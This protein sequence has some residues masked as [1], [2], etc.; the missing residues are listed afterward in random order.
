MK[1]CVYEELPTEI[2]NKLTYANVF[3]QKCYV[4]FVRGDKEEVYYLFD[5]ERIM[6]VRYRKKY[7]FRFAM[8]LSEP[9]LYVEKEHNELKDFLN[10]A[11]DTLCSKCHIQWCVSNTSALFYDT[12]DRN[13]KRIPFGS[14]V[15][16][17]DQDDETIWSKVHSKHRNV[18]RKAEKEGVVIK[19]GGAELLDDYA[20]LEA[21]TNIR[22]GRTARGKAYYNKQVTFL[23]E[24]LKVYIAYNNGIPQ[25]GGIFFLNPMC[26]Y[27][28]FGATAIHSITGAANLLLWTA[29]K[30]A[31]EMK[32]KSFSF[33]G[34]RI[35]EDL[36]SKY[37]GIQRFKERFGGELKKGYLFRCE[38]KHYM[39]SLFCKAMQF[40][41]HQK[42]PY[43]TPIDDEL[44]KWVDIQ[45]KGKW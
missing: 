32:V 23:K 28:M 45:E 35:N 9:L 30:D 27:Y 40:R 25:A 7:I 6:P 14:H 2:K 37:H 20:C 29:I 33:V 10:S 44:H 21:E 17:L 4:D 42:A 18:I 3:F 5:N 39:Y 24:N 43:S 1:M 11:L 31:K 34:C 26:C 22:T 12:P 8:L 19:C 38:K 13:C 16:D 41:L 15:I 36:E